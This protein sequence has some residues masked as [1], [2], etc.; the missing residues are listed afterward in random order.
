[1]TRPLIKTSSSTEA[2]AVFYEAFRHSDLQVMSALWADGEVV[3]VHPGSGIISGYDAVMQSWQHI[4]NNSTPTDIEFSLLHRS[5]NNDLAV[6]VVTEEFRSNDTLNA[7]VIATNVYRKFSHGWQIIE[8]HA[9][10][11]AS[12]IANRTLQ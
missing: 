3:C 5:V 12:D 4:L 11:T 9:S 7:I 8:H 1:M 6:H 2:E 10:I